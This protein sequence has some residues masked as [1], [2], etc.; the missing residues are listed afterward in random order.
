MHHSKSKYPLLVAVTEDV[1]TDELAKT[2]E[3]NGILYRRIRPLQYSELTREKYKG[4][5]FLNTASKIEVFNFCNWDKLVYIDADCMILHNIDDLFDY[6]DGSMICYED[7]P[8][9]CSSLFVIEP[10]KHDE[11]DYLYHLL[12]TQDCF[13]GNLIGKLWFHVKS[14]PAHQIP[15]EYQW[16]YNPIPIPEGTKM[17]HFCN[18]AKPWLDNC[19]ESISVI[20]VYN[21]FLRKIERENLIISEN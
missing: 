18:D 9:G 19:D 4:H 6:P 7:E 20:K 11:V 2:F 10:K 8:W 13:D 17:I 1:F 14:S 12:K 3:K 15:P 16:T 5:R 21:Y